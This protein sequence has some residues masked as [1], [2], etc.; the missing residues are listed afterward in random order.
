MRQGPLDQLKDFWVPP[1]TLG[2][3]GPLTMI[4]SSV[5]PFS[6][7]VKYNFIWDNNYLME[8][9]QMCQTLHNIL[10]SYV[11]D[12]TSCRPPP[13]LPW[14][15][16]IWRL[17][18]KQRRDRQISDSRSLCVS[19]S[20]SLSLCL[21]VSLSL[22]PSLSLFCCWRT[23]GGGSGGSARCC[24]RTGSF[25]FPRRA[26]FLC[27]PGRGGIWGADHGVNIAIIFGIFSSISTTLYFLLGSAGSRGER[28]KIKLCGFAVDFHSG[29]LFFSLFLNYCS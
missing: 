16:W 24:G 29:K 19:P 26:L 4:A 27:A 6:T 12:M 21:S 22:H 10:K 1:P 11:R 8:M 5:C 3:T 15:D 20:L 14:P 13:R 17:E 18:A 7:R 2:P 9:I 23:G 25:P 28:T